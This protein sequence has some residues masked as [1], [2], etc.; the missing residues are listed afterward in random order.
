[1]PTERYEQL[2]EARELAIK[3]NMTAQQKQKQQSDKTQYK[4]E[5]KIGDLLLVLQPKGCTGQ[6][7]KLRH[8][9]RGPYKVL[10]KY[11]DLVYLVKRTDQ[12]RDD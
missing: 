4:Q 8:P 10:A 2:H 6:T 7:T 5:F 12:I 3:A 11:S 9:Y 1:M